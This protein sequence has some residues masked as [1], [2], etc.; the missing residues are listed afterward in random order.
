VF[1]AVE[2]ISNSNNHAI[3]KALFFNKPYK[4]IEKMR[5]ITHLVRDM[6]RFIPLWNR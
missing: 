5:H 4:K 6:P 2:R 3:K 1:Y